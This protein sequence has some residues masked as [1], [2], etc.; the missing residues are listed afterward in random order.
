MERFFFLG[1]VGRAPGSD[2]QCRG[3]NRPLVFALVLVGFMSCK[4]K[5]PELVSNDASSY[6]IST[7]NWPEKPDVHAKAE[8]VLKD[9]EE[10]NALET[11]F[12]ALYHV[13]NRDDLSL[14]VDDLIDKQKAL[15]A[16]EYPETFDRPQVKSRLKV[17]KTYM[18][19]VKG[20]F[21]Y[22]NATEESVLQMINAYN[23]FR[24]QFNVITNNALDTELILED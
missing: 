11:S 18:L 19:K 5:N 4:E 9:W 13:A 21:F 23:A 22:R 14:A 16:S 6:E 2:M 15:E 20:D 1:C 7:E 17:F 24:N 12:D 10:Y 3:V 8:A